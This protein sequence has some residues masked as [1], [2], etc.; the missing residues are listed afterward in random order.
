MTMHIQQE[1]YQAVY[2]VS[3]KGP[4]NYNLGVSLTYDRGLQLV[5]FGVPH[6][7]KLG[8]SWL[9]VFITGLRDVGDRHSEREEWEFEGVLWSTKLHAKKEGSRYLRAKVKG[10][11][12]SRTREGMLYVLAHAQPRP[13]VEVVEWSEMAVR[14]AQM[15]ERWGAAFEDRDQVTGHWVRGNVHSVCFSEDGSLSFNCSSTYHPCPTGGWESATEGFFLS[16]PPMDQKPVAL[17][18]ERF[19]F[20]FGNHDYVVYQ[21]RYKP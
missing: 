4:N 16:R 12:N 17:A 6:P 18:G 9:D 20:A 11:Y 5:Q 8:D 7:E 14:V 19:I 10:T 21:G 15:I 1:V 2:E 13:H 3:G